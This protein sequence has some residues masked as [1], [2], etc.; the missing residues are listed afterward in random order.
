DRYCVMA[1]AIWLDLRR[2]QCPAASGLLL[3]GEDPQVLGAA[4][5]YRKAQ[6]R[7]RGDQD[8]HSEYPTAGAKA[9]GMCA[10]G[11]WAVQAGGLAAPLFFIGSVIS[12]ETGALT[13][14]RR[15]NLTNG[16]HE[17]CSF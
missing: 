13:R 15:M 8:L 17:K 2:S 3:H 14:S 9:G 10:F 7:G 16:Q 6:G 4:Q 5:H 12:A 1:R 11:T